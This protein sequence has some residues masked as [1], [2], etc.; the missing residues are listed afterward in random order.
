MFH[1]ILI[2]ALV[3]LLAPLDTCAK[4]ERQR[5]RTLEDG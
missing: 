4:E 2:I 3:P 5:D 1:R